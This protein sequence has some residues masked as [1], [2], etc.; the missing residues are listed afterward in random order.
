DSI[1]DSG[2]ASASANALKPEEARTFELGTKW[3]LFNN[4]ANLTAAVFRTEKQN[5]R[6]QIDPTTTANAGK[7]KVDGFEVSLNGK[8]TDKW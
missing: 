7:S 8:I 3:D 1:S 5:T 4:R 6:I 2:T